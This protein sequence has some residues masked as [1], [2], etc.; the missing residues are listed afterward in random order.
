M[1]IQ[2]PT[3]TTTELL[4]ALGRSSGGTGGGEI[5]WRTLDGR[6]RP[7]VIAMVRRLGLLPEEA[8]EV[9]QQSLAEVF[10]GYRRGHYE[11]SRGR[12][13]SW[14]IGIARHRAIDA[15]RRRGRAVGGTVATPEIPD[16]AGLTRIWDEEWTQHLARQAMETLRASSELDER[17]IQAFELFAL[18]GVPASEAAAACAMT[19][20][21]VY[22]AKNRVAERLREIIA[23]LS[24]TYSEPE[25]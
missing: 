5:A 24:L 6:M 9:A 7:V 20:S 14:I 21:Q 15:F 8:E 18:R 23:E 10:E 25:A 1:N 2:T 17:T 22:V 19:P 3:I 11:R 13:R 12:L 4:E 16:H